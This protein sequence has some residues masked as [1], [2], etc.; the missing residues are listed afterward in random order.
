MKWEFQLYAGFGLLI[1]LLL[2]LQTSILQLEKGSVSEVNAIDSFNQLMVDIE[3]NVFLM[4]GEKQNILVEGP[5]NKIRNIET[6]N[7]GGCVTVKEKGKR[8]I[9]RVMDFIKHRNDRV[10]IYITVNNLDDICIET[11]DEQPEVKYT[12]EDIIGL[13]LRNG[14]TLFLEPKGA[15]S[16]V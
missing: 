13:T 10:N 3:C 15:K 12:A 8:L 16:C 4:K 14:N 11:N 1:V 2:L 7:N 6:V 5:G 9:S